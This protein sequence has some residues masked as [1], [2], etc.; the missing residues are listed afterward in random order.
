MGRFGTVLICLRTKTSEN[1]RN[2]WTVWEIISLSR[3]SLRCGIRWFCII[4][5]KCG[6]E[7][8]W[9]RYCVLSQHDERV[10]KLRPTGRMF[11]HQNC[12][13]GF[14]EVVIRK[15]CI[16]GTLRKLASFNFVSNDNMADVWHWWQQHYSCLSP[17][18]HH[19]HHPHPPPPTPPPPPPTPPPPPPPPPRAIRLFCLIHTSFLLEKLD[20]ATNMNEG[21]KS[22]WALLMQI[23]I[24]SARRLFPFIGVGK[25]L[26]LSYWTV[27]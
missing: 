17:P 23:D 9:T 6:Y 12:W 16:I 2:I 20:C 19:H 5:K 25:I 10:W 8:V 26:L 21:E 22:I 14:D 15:V 13:L 24:A 7:L 4:L 27:C 3:K 18:L 11:R 1:A